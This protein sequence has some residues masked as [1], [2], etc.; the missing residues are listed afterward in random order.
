MSYVRKIFSLEKK[1]AIVTGAAQGN[2]KAISEALLKA[3]STVILVDISKKQL[4]KTHKHFKSLKL[5]S[6][7]FC[8][9]I[10]SQ[11]SL[12]SLYKF[13]ITKFKRIDILVNNAG[14]THPHSIIN[15]PEEFWNK[16]YEVNLK[17]PFNL[18]KIFVKTMK[19]QHSGIIINI[20]SINAELAFPDNSAYV[21]FKGAL[22]QLTKSLAL[23]LGKW[24]IRV[25]SVGP[26]YFRT[27]MTKNSWSNVKR[28]KQIANKTILNRWG[29]PKDLE[30][31]IVFLASDSSSYITGQDIYVD[32]GWIAKG[33]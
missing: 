1:I 30:G 10:T 33:I 32:G 3:G 31:L 5:K 11:E 22:K 12:E 14:V 25:N 19:K 17:A 6:Y 24:N 15:Y 18:S 8:C 27:E 7:M 20:T 9:D 28:R 4:E 23:D 21:A 2:G 26:G 29:T 16:T 13:V